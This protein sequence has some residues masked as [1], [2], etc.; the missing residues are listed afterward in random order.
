MDI[1]SLAVAQKALAEIGISA[2]T[3]WHS[4]TGAPAAGLGE[5]GDFY[6]DTNAGDVYEKTG[7]SSWT[8]VLNVLG[9]IG[10]TGP[11]GQ[12]GPTGPQGDTGPTGPTDIADGLAVVKHGSD[13]S[14]ARP[15]A[16]SVYWMGSVDPTNRE[17]GDWWLETDA[18]DG[19]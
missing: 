12:T 6:L 4:G 17:L 2:G 9:A 5:A 1:L 11:T 15:A 19:S 3:I 13:D 10:P 7:A 14:V 8:L 16:G 18:Y